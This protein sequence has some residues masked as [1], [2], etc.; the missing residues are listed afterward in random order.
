MRDAHGMEIGDGMQGA[1]KGGVQTAA[2]KNDVDEMQA[3][4]D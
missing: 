3:K 2:K 4:L 1:A